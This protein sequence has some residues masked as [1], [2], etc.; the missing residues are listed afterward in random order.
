VDTWTQ[1]STATSLE[2][3]ISPDNT[4]T[5]IRAMLLDVYTYI[6]ICTTTAIGGG[7]ITVDAYLART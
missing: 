7:T 3:S 6:P 1:C 4:I 2:G 5:I